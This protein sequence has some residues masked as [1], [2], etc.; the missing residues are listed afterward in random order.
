MISTEFKQKFNATA[1]ELNI[2]PIKV[3]PHYLE[4]VKEENQALGC[5]GGPLYRVVYPIENR[6]N[7]RAPNEVPDFVEDHTNMPPC[8]ASIFTNTSTGHCF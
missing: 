3:T 2:L 8:L 6:L 1:K 4:L 5:S 7:I